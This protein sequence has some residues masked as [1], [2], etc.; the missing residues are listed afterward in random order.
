[1]QRIGCEK[2]RRDIHCADV[3]L[4]MQDKMLPPSKQSE[5][6]AFAAKGSEIAAPETETEVERLSI[7]T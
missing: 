6:M 4:R 5:S 3:L 2:K 1:M 7:M